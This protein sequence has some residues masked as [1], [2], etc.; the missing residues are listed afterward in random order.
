MKRIIFIALV[1]LVAP[2]LAFAIDIDVDSNDATDI[3][4]GGTNATTEADAR[5]NLGVAIGTDI[6][7]YD[8]NLPTW[9]AT[10]D[11]T[12]VGYLNGVT[13]AIQDQL[14]AKG[15]GDMLLGTAQNVTATK[16][17]QDDIALVFGSDAD[18]SILYDE[19]TGDQLEI[20]SNSATDTKITI[21]NAG[22]GVTDM[23]I[24]GNFEAASYSSTP[25]AA[26]SQASV[27]WEDT[28]SGSEFFGI[29]AAANITT[30]F[31]IG[32]P[33]A[34]GTDGQVLAITGTPAARTW[35]DGVS[36]LTAETVWA[37]PLLA[38]T[39]SL[40]TTVTGI[41]DTEILVGNG[42][43]SGAFVVVSGDATLANTGALTLA[44]IVDSISW[45]AGGMVADGTQC[46]DPAKVT[47]NSGPA[48]YTI[49]CADNDA[50]TIYGH[51]LMPDSWDGGTVTLELEYLQSAADTGVLNADVAAQC[52]GAGETVSN[53]WGTEVALDD[54]AVTGSNAVDHTTT[55]A[56]TPAGT[57]AGG[58]SLYWRY[59]IDATGTTTA[60]A[61]L[62]HIGAKVEY[63][64]TVGD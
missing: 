15:V 35:S 31:M 61:T 16:E 53:T 51:V 8:A 32:S 57:C 49:I 63:T 29:G 28:D 64:S 13:S 50:S 62:H 48:D 19:T 4:Y 27:Q 55:A 12:E 14:G 3:A 47:I 52:R 5:T 21:T 37:T 38:E 60:V 24:D 10:V 41:A 25:T 7:A 9:P 44:D 56:I 6:Q 45:N 2:S 18:F 36:R 17:M 33:A 59:Q 20:T 39:N 22:A 42:A 26:G 46:A 11:A 1:L 54:A 34:P 23:S 58:D 43:D 40:E 30:S